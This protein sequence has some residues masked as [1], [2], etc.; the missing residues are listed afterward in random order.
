MVRQVRFER[1]AAPGSQIFCVPEYF[2]HRKHT[3]SIAEHG[4]AEDCLFF[5]VFPDSEF[6]GIYTDMYA[7][8]CGFYSRP[9]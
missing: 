5:A 6:A 4:K 3:H 7:L 2:P 1:R 9:R 8:S